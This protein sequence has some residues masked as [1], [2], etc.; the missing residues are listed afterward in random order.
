[1]IVFINFSGRKD[2][3]KQFYNKL[4]MYGLGPILGKFE[5]LKDIKYSIQDFERYLL[6]DNND[7]INQMNIKPINLK[8]FDNL[9]SKLG[10]ENMSCKVCQPTLNNYYIKDKPRSLY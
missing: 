6:K 9:G 3:K 2:L 7:Y 4:F 8:L 1:V 10:Y 5:S